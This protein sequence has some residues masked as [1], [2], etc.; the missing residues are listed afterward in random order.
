MKTR[1]NLMILVFII[2]VMSAFT[3]SASCVETS[4]SLDATVATARQKSIDALSSLAKGY[5]DPSSNLTYMPINSP[6]LEGWF[7]V[8][9][10]FSVLNHL[11]MQPGYILDYVFHS[12]GA[13]GQP[14]LYA[15]RIDSAPFSTLNELGNTYTDKS[16][17]HLY[18]Y[19]ANIK[20]DDTEESYFQ[21]I[22]LRIMGGQF[23]LA[24]HANYNDHA[25]V[26]NPEGVNK[27]ISNNKF[28]RNEVII[29]LQKK[30]KK[31]NL[32]PEIEIKENVVIVKV[33]I[34]TQWGGLIQESYTLARQFPHSVLDIKN[35]ILFGYN[36]ETRF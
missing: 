23:Y 22:A 35:K 17:T 30:V 36:S 2:S 11:S 21:Y 34:F 32:E 29:K 20:T 5:V 4:T 3:L 33:V 31:L 25:V 13:D 8:N 15:R 28:I 14:Y 24:W 7:D 16:I 18:D 9:E 19:M 12:D 27:L 1:Q 10:Y 6:K 26:C